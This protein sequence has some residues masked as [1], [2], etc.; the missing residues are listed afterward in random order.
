MAQVLFRESEKKWALLMLFFNCSKKITHV[1][2]T[3]NTF[4]LWIHFLCIDLE[5]VKC[6]NCFKYCSTQKR[7]KEVTWL[8]KNVQSSAVQVEM[9]VLSWDDET[10]V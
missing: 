9:M 10:L 5:R 8:P 2:D 6:K 1:I 7:E 4:F 3:L